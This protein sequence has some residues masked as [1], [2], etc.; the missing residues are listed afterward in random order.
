MCFSSK[1]KTPK[2]NPESI[3]APEPVL[4]EQPKGVEFGA[5]DQTDKPQEDGIDGLKVDKTS[6]SDKGDGSGT[7]STSDSGLTKPTTSAPIK[8]AI[9]KVTK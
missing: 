4:I 3:K 2:T 1:A 5:G 6:T 8:R 9:K 7:A